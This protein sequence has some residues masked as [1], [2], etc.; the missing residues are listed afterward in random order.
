LLWKHNLSLEILRHIIFREKIIAEIH[1]AVFKDRLPHVFHQANQEAQIVDGH[2]ARALHVENILKAMRHPKEGGAYAVYVEDAFL[3]VNTGCYG[4]RYS[5][6]G[7]VSVARC[8][9]E[10]DLSVSV[11]A[12]TQ[13]AFGF[14]NLEEAAYRPD[15]RIL[16]NEATLQKVFVKKLLFLSDFY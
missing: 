7:E 9:G 8:E 6:N 11:Q 4:V 15:V 5:G 14:L 12:F 1:Q 10:A 3:P 16:S 2:E 13:L